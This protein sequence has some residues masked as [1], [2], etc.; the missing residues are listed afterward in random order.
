MAVKDP[1]T[2]LLWTGCLLLCA[3]LL[4]PGHKTLGN[5]RWL[6]PRLY[7]GIAFLFISVLVPLNILITGRSSRGILLEKE[8]NLMLLASFL[9][10]GAFYL[11]WRLVF[12]IHPKFAPKPY[13][14][15]PNQY[16]LRALLL[17]PVIIWTFYAFFE[18]IQ[19]TE[20]QVIYTFGRASII[21]AAIL[22][23]LAAL[24]KKRSLDVL[25]HLGMAAV[26]FAAYIWLSFK[27][28]ARLMFLFI[29]IAVFALLLFA[30]K[31]VRVVSVALLG[32]AFVW[33]FILYGNARYSVIFENNP[34]GEALRQSAPRSGA[35]IY[36][37]LFIS[38]DLD[39]FENGTLVLNMIPSKADY[40]WGKTFA[41]LLVMPIPR[42]WWP[43]KP[44]ASVNY[45]LAEYYGFYSDNFAISLPAE[46][47]ANF[48]WPG[49][50]IVFLIYGM[51][52]AALYARTWVMRKEPEKWIYLG[53]YCAYL[54]LVM[55]GSFHSM[56][57]YYLMVVFWIFLSGQLVRVSAKARAWRATRGTAPPT[58]RSV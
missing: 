31:R 8:T 22:M 53:L 43:D 56:T 11:G 30:V 15:A 20:W 3:L 37:R 54:I 16:V 38:G 47:Y 17:L 28:S 50:V 12:K 25:P 1:V 57:S 35:D 2:W 40:Y 44:V 46:T 5:L 29:L 19:E 41:T 4:R 34:L 33:F 39:A 36:N 23:T 48:S 6:N 32:L 42:A 27:Q 14:F 9:A 13:E 55:R 58:I 10:A 45:L 51:I 26:F 49:I 18:R 52:S 7:F 24:K 21:G